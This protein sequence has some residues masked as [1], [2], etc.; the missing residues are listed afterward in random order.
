MSASASRVCPRHYRHHYVRAMPSPCVPHVPHIL[1]PPISESC[2]PHTPSGP[3]RIMMPS[4]SSSCQWHWQPGSRQ[5]SESVRVLLGANAHLAI[6]WVH[7]ESVGLF[8]NSEHWRSFGCSLSRSVL[9]MHSEHWVHHESVGPFTVD[10]LGALRVGRSFGVH[11]EHMDSHPSPLDPSE[12]SSGL[13]SRSFL[14]SRSLGAAC[15]ILDLAPVI[16]RH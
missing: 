14:P 3:V 4:L 9:S 11:S 15:W 8:G 12:P 1:P 16:G 7:F 13:P 6:L 2:P 5:G 10:P